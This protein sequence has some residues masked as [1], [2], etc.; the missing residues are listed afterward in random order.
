MFSRF[1]LKTANLQNVFTAKLTFQIFNRRKD[2]TKLQTC[3]TF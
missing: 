2:N 1:A 3:K